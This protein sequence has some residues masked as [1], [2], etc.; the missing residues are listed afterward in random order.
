M[1]T[2]VFGAPAALSIHAPAAIAPQTATPNI[3]PLSLAQTRSSL[4]TGLR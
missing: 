2:I 1:A 3:C 4:M